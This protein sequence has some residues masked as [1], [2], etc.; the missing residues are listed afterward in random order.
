MQ[1]MKKDRNTRIEEIVVMISI[2]NDDMHIYKFNMLKHNVI[3]K[4]DKSRI[5]NKAL[6]YK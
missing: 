6:I 1:T 4:I 2:M 3:A 5:I